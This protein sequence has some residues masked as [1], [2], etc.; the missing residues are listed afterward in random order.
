[1]FKGESLTAVAGKYSMYAERINV[2]DSLNKE[3][4]DEARH[5]K[6]HAYENYASFLARK[7]AKINDARQKI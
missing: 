3:I 1:M 7:Y 2:F 4:W 5:L 6:M